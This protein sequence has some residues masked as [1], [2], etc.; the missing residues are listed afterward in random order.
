MAAVNNS[1][2]VSDE[3][4]RRIA[5]GI[6]IA[7]GYRDKGSKPNKP[8]RLNNPGD[9][10]LD[11]TG[12]AIGKEGAI[13]KYATYADGRAALEAQ[14][15]KFFKGSVLYSPSMTLL[16]VAR[17]YTATA[18]EQGAWAATVARQFGVSVT[19]RLEELV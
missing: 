7:E 9:L 14:V 3:I 12:T 16:E 13:L 11:I 19:T 2:S 15:R 4:I 6:E 5:D 8:Q 10:T 17:K 1:G 18:S